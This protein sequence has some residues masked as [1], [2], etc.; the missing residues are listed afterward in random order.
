MQLSVSIPM[1][2]LQDYS[3][4]YRPSST[5][6][7]T[8]LCKELMLHTRP[9]YKAKFS[10]NQLVSILSHMYMLTLHS[11][12][13]CPLSTVYIYTYIIYIYIYIIHIYIYIIYIYIYYSNNELLRHHLHNSVL[14]TLAKI[15]QRSDA[16]V[17][18]CMYP[19]TF[20]SVHTS[21]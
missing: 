13:L 1:N 4:I 17:A 10:C 14:L 11:R 3:A 18:S 9:I 12:A 20:I 6:Y 16:S 2:W 21:H 7:I 15:C 19:S 8:V 5:V